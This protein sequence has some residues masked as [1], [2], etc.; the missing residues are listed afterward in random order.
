MVVAVLSG[1]RSTRKIQTVITKKDTVPVITVTD[2]RADSIRFIREVYD[3]VMDNRL[4]YRTFSAKVKVDFV[5]SDGKKSDFN[6]FIRMK[7]DS[8]LWL[9]INAAFGIETIHISIT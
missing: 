3:K 2:A 5:G 7:K 4:D 9:T 6:A 1:C 8:V